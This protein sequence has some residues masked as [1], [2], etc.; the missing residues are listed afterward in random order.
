[1]HFRAISDSNQLNGK[2]KRNQEGLFDQIGEKKETRRLL[3]QNNSRIYIEY[4][5][6]IQLVIA[7]TPYY[8]INRDYNGS[9]KISWRL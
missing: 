6:A 9:I 5:I 1:M 7:N 3:L 2:Q 8:I 4:K